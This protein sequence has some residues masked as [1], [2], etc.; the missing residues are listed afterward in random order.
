MFKL[1]LLLVLLLACASIE[2]DVLTKEKLDAI[3]QHQDYKHYFIFFHQPTLDALM[4]GLE[5]W[6]EHGTSAA[7]KTSEF[8]LTI[9]AGTSCPS[10]RTPRRA[11]CSFSSTGY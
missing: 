7:T 4:E 5:A 2:V 10:A 9:A 1:T 6:K 11:P 3:K 8:T